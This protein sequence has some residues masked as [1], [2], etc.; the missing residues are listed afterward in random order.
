MCCLPAVAARGH[1]P[2]TSHNGAGLSPSQTEF[3]N[4]LCVRHHVYRRAPVPSNSPAKPAPAQNLSESRPSKTAPSRYQN[5]NCYPLLPVFRKSPFGVPSECCV[6]QHTTP[7]WL[8]APGCDAAI[9]RCWVLP[10]SPM[11]RDTLHQSGYPPEEA[12]CVN[13]DPCSCLRF[14]SRL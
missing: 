12:E 5:T 9:G 8:E 14:R 1:Q 3:S 6:R 7:L 2:R 4:L 13:S 10:T 11:G